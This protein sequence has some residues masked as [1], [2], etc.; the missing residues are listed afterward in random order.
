MRREKAR[1]VRRII[2]NK[3]I[4]EGKELGGR[5]GEKGEVVI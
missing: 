4:E 1:K 5:E 2:K 3:W